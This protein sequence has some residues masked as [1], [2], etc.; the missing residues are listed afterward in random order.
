MTIARASILTYRAFSSTRLLSAQLASHRSCLI[1]SKLE[2]TRP[3]N[4]TRTP[5]HVHPRPYSTTTNPNPSTT[6]I[7][8]MSVL[9]AP[10]LPESVTNLQPD[11]KPKLHLYTAATPNG[12]KPSILLE[13]LIDAYPN[14]PPLYDYTSL[15]F[16]EKHQKTPEFL[17]INPNGRI[18]ALVDDNTQVD[19]KGHNVFESIS[20]LLWLVEKYD[21]ENKFWFGNGES[22][23]RSKGFSWIVSGSGTFFGGKYSFE[24]FLTVFSSFFGLRVCGSFPHHLGSFSCMHCHA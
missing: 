5:T 21:P 13:E 15:S 12:Y 7:T 11:A 20:V 14:S 19:G 24:P 22:V 9:P 3:F 17:K 18:P 6:T 10:Q 2:Q 8:T 4:S 1:S 16:A 23:L